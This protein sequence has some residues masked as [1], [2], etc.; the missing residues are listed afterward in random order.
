MLPK[1]TVLT[2]TNGCRTWLY[3]SFS[4]IHRSATYCI[5]W[6]GSANV[7]VLRKSTLDGHGDTGFARLGA[8]R[9]SVDLDWVL[10]KTLTGE[11]EE[12]MPLFVELI[13][14]W[15]SSIC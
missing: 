14:V 11:D 5:G 7:P 1:K 4:F 6:P 2:E 15:Q 12:T 9:L 10:P 8:C 13:S 3:P